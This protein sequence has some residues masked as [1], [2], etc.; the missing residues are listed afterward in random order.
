MKLSRREKI[1]RQ[2]EEELR[3]KNLNYVVFDIHGD[4]I[5]RPKN[6]HSECFLFP[7]SDLEKLYSTNFKTFFPLGVN[8]VRGD[9]FLILIARVG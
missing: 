5:I 2:I 8:I 1:R 6:L 4:F 9:V 7:S 3:N